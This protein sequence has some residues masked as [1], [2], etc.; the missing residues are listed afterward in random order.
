MTNNIIQLYKKKTD[1]AKKA[2]NQEAKDIAAK[3]KIDQRIKRKIK[4]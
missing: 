3:L 1:S 4:Q 2:I